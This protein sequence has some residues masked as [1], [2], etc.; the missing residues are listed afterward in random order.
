MPDPNTD[1]NTNN[2]ASSDQP[3][4]S[5]G[6]PTPSSIFPQ[7]D[8]P[9]LPPD[10]QNVSPTV[11]APV[12]SPVAEPVA[13]SGSASPS[14][15]IPTTISTPPKKKFGGGRIIATI[16]GL[17]LLIG[18][19]GAGIL[20]T[21]Q[22]QIF[23]PKAGVD[24]GGPGSG[25]PA[26]SYC[27]ISSDCG[28][29]QSCVNGSCTTTTCQAGYALVN[30]RC[31]P[32]GNCQNNQGDCYVKTHIGVGEVDKQVCDNEH[33]T[34]CAPGYICANEDCIPG[35]SNPPS[36][37]PSNPPSTPPGPTAQCLNVR[38]YSGANW[39]LLTPESISMI[40][41]GDVVNF[42]VAGNASVGTFDRAQ[43]KINGV[44]KPET[45]TKR[46]TSNDFCQSYTVLPT[47]TAI[48]TQAKIHHATLG[49]FG[50]TI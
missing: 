5:I 29:G 44:L 37:P 49:W 28:S 30:G 20:L 50:E 14:N 18:G 47:D 13:N 46:P 27:Q 33:W 31:V 24:T 1:P 38:A 2:S 6:N 22:Q 32:P 17:F 41:P 35:P 45:T 3:S 23:Q 43:F 48:S 36:H 21:Q 40:R 42:C 34:T 7:S 8:A 9:P 11:P 15:N 10:F 39:V 12:P 25:L 26:V 19:V 4:A 16:L